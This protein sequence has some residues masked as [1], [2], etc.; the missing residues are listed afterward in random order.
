M[1]IIIA[2]LSVVIIF[3]IILPSVKHI[4]SLEK[5]INTTQ[6]FLEQQYEKTQKM[7]SSIHGL[8]ETISKT[9]KFKD[10]VVQEGRELS[11][12]TELEKIAINND[13]DQ[14]IKVNLITP[15]T[16]KKA[17]SEDKNFPR[18]LLNRPYYNFS[19]EN[20]GR[21]QNHVEYLKS[22]DKL[23]YYFNIES[24]QFIKENVIGEQ[25]DKGIVELRFNAKIF[26]TEN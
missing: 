23:S 20:K 9:E 7:R 8:D 25:E 26:T 12:I 19:F 10:I 3:V 21:F 15:Q 14:S 5:D 16:G 1:T 22:L 13:I 2:I 17:S 18:L 24:M 11:V 6:A 4:L